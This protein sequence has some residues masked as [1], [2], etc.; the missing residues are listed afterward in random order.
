M[1]EQHLEKNS[2]PNALD[3]MRT[4]VRRAK[5]G[6]PKVLPKLRRFFDK[7]PEVWMHFA[8]L[9]L[10]VE[11]AWI[12]LLAGDNLHIKEALA[13]RALQ[14]Q[15]ELEGESPTQLEQLLARRIVTTW[16][17][18]HAYEALAVENFGQLGKGQATALE[19]RLDSAN[20]RRLRAIKALA[21]ARRL[22]PKVIELRVRVYDEEAKDPAEGEEGQNAAEPD[23]SIEPAKETVAVED[24][25]KPSITERPDHDGFSDLFEDH[26]EG[27]TPTKE[28]DHG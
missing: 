3:E 17:T 5:A 16:L 26:S 4:L 10:H 25:C 28:K 6:D 20:Q 2:E 27:R 7:H 18:L 11:L 14:M 13:R 22:L 12:S 21:N 8:D 23:S 9:S 24:Q 15:L 19:R 1:A